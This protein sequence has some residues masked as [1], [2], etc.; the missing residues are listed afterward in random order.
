MT[1][2]TS[3]PGITF[4]VQQVERTTEPLPTCKTHEALNRLLACKVEGCCDYTSDCIQKVSF[5]PLLAAAHFAFSQH[6][7]LVLSPDMIWVAVVQGL[8]RHVRNHAERLR[9]QFVGHQGKLDI[10]IERTDLHRGSQENAWDDVIHDLSL[11]IQTHLGPRYEELISDFSTTGPV[12]RTAC[13]VALLDAF[14]PYFEYRVYCICGIPEI[15]HEKRPYFN[16]GVMVVV[17]RH[18]DL[19]RTP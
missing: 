3:T 7:P 4:A 6:R 10:C 11:A 18:R 17:Q 13:E 19:F 8:A 2:R 15:T 16:T 12:E 14:Q 5:H 9:D 1:T